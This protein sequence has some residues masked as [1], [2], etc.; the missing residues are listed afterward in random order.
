MTIGFHFKAKIIKILIIV[1][2]LP[3]VVKAELIFKKN[4]SIIK[5]RV[6]KDEAAF[7]VVKDES[8]TILRIRQNDVIRVFYKKLSLGKLFIRLTDGSVRYGYLIDEDRETYTFRVKLNEPEEFTLP[9]EKV[10]FLARTNPHELTGNAG[11]E[12]VDLKWVASF[13]QAK[14]YNVYMKSPDK[15][16]HLIIKTKDT[17][18]AVKG[19]KSNTRYC[20]KVTAIDSFGEETLPTNEIEIITKNI[21]PETPAG[22]VISKIISPDGKSATVDIS[23]EGSVDPDGRVTGYNI[24]QEAGGILRKTGTSITTAFTVEGLD[25]YKTYYFIVRSVDDIGDESADSRMVDTGKR[26]ITVSLKGAYLFPAG[27]LKKLADKGYGGIFGIGLR[28]MPFDRFIAGVDFGYFHI[29]GS[30]DNIDSVT[31][32][33]VMA[34]AGIIMPLFSF[35][36]AVP[37]I[38]AGYSYNSITYK[39]RSTVDAG[40]IESITRS[41]FDPMVTA[42][43]MVQG[44]IAKSVILKAG[45]EYST[46]LEKD[47]RISFYSAFAGAYMIF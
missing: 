11:T 18:C 28:G 24:Y 47:G 16:Y 25:P 20:Y 34:K 4:G 27:E 32:I 31:I 43:F 6:I 38:G 33:P 8:G 44:D 26:G 2:V 10:L 5:G 45:M 39:V 30:R 36:S 37:S 3:V 13:S 23:W 35:I 21:L 1:V 22:I 29:T 17:F 41:G 46:L 42:G 40:K 7:L 12:N 19:L 14:G 15:D 9:I